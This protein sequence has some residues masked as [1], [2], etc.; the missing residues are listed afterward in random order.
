MPHVYCPDFLV[1]SPVVWVESSSVL[2][3]PDESDQHFKP[4]VQSVLVR[5]LDLFMNWRP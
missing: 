5:C 4:N 2:V 1:T 3:D